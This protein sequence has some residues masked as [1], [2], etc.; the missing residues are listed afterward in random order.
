[1][2]LHLR[3]VALIFPLPAYVFLKHFDTHTLLEA[4]V[5]LEKQEMCM[6]HDG[7]LSSTVLLCLYVFI[8]FFYRGMKNA[9]RALYVAFCP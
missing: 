2:Y 1:M 4:A 6:S 3:D 5:A 8:I 9:L 7:H